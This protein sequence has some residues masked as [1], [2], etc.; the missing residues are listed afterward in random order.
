M[1]ARE[2]TDSVGG[3]EFVLVEKIAKH[4]HEPVAGGDGEQ[5]V[6]MGVLTFGFQIG[7][8]P[9]EIRPVIEKPLHPFAE[10]GEFG[11]DVLFQNLDRKQGDDPDQRTHL[12]RDGTAV[13]VQLIVVKPIFLIPETAPAQ[14]VNGV[15]DGHKVLEKFRSHIFVGRI[16]LGEFQSD[17]QHGV[18]IKGHPSRA[19]GLLKEPASRQGL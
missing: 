2:R 18:T 1:D 9:G 12:E 11:N 5:A 7:A 6:V 19:I 15:G 4:L 13:N 10:S 3:E 14:G 16:A 8:L 17:G